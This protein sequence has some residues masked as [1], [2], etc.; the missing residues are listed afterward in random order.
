MASIR[1]IKCKKNIKDR[2]I[3][4][5]DHK[6]FYIKWYYKGTTYTCNRN[7]KRERLDAVKAMNLYR[8]IEKDLAKYE[9]G[10]ASSPFNKYFPKKLSSAAKSFTLR[11]SEKLILATRKRAKS[12]KLECDLD[13]QYVFDMVRSQNGRCAL[14]GLRFSLDKGKSSAWIP[15][16]LSIDRIDSK[17]G[18]VKGNIRL[19][20][21][22]VNVALHTWGEIIFDQIVTARYQFRFNQPETT[23]SKYRGI[24]WKTEARKWV[25]RIII[26][27][28]SHFLGLFVSELDAARAYDDAVKKYSLDPSKL[29]F[30]DE[31]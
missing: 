8:A 7:L 4:T 27:G 1:C 2:N 9:R 26:D 28:K 11:D 19:V 31:T 16:K 14:T 24:Y 10:E 18:Y 15:F 6:Y 20:C 17:K 13:A 30:K 12:R 21:L 3:S 29:N 23:T 25:S 22:A 5:C